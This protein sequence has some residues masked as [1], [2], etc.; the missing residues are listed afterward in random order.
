MKI[1]EGNRVRAVALAGALMVMAA[2]ATAVQTPELVRTLSCAE[3]HGQ[4]GVSDNSRVPSDF[5]NQQR[6]SSLQLR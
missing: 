5:L 4:G 3:C 2:P 1:T 6:A